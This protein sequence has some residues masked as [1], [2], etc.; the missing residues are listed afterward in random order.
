MIEHDGLMIASPEYNSS[1]S[2]VLKNVIDWVS[3]PEEGETVPL[4][5]FRGK[6]V[7]IMSASPSDWG[8]LRGLVILRSMLENIQCMVLPQQITVPQAHN[9]F[10]PDGQLK[11]DAL[12]ERVYV[13][14]NTLA[15]ILTKLKG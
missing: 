7:A 10:T 13:Q 2:G 6:I 11:D 5:A 15:D 4:P 3:R 12:E 8:G 1:I 14:A 9:A